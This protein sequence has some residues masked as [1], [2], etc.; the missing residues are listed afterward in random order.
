MLKRHKRLMGWL[1]VV[2]IIAALTWAYRWPGE[3][4][5]LP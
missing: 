5:T 3:G 2:L 4:T 1:V